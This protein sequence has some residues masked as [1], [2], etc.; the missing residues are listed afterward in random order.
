MKIMARRWERELIKHW[1]IAVSAVFILFLWWL[2]YF[3]ALDRVTL[4]VD[5]QSYQWQTISPNVAAVLKEKKVVL[6]TGDVVMPSVKTSIQEGTEIQVIRAF[7]VKIKQAG[8]ITECFS[9]SQPVKNVLYLANVKYDTDDKVS[10]GLEMMVKPGQVIRITNVTTKILT[11]QV[12]LNPATEYQKDRNLERGEQ[13]VL[14][15]G[16]SGLVERSIKVFYEDGL[17]TRSVT[18]TQ[19]ILKPTLNT[20]IALGIK[21]VI[22][23]LA[24]SRGSYRYVELKVMNATA[25]SPGP[26]SCGKYAVYGRTYLGKKAGFG[27][28]AVDPRVIPLG[29]KL[30]IEGYGTALAGDI[31]GAIKGNRIDLC[32]ETYR[33]AEMFGRR[34]IKVYILE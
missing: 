22:R 21:P 23:T 5:G 8:V 25:Y 29:T 27:I 26:E 30:Y 28:V 11:R 14:R 12:V 2:I 31:G 7:P 24:T 13:K 3:I 19:K 9:I 18:L 17:E 33:E 6:K 10:P 20:I 32:F 34:K 15:Q 16:K 1:Q 4:K